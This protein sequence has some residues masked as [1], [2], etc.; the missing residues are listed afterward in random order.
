MSEFSY[1]SRL[2]KHKQEMQSVE[3]VRLDQEELS[4][5]YTFKL[6]DLRIQPN[7]HIS[8]AGEID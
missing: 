4:R 1:E 7:E 3:A 2:A 8:E 5:R 6:D